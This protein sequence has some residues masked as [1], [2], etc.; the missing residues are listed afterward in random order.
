MSGRPAAS[1]SMAS[2]LRPTTGPF[3]SR[4]RTRPSDTASPAT[5][6]GRT[7]HPSCSS[8][9]SSRC[10]PYVAAHAGWVVLTF[11]LYATTM[12]AI[13]GDRIGYLLAGAFPAVLAN[14]VAGQ[15]G[16][17]TAALL[18]GTLGLMEKRPVL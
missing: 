10:F 4:C 3:T 7:L 14:A 9:R 17:V 6:N 13:V 8:R 1:C 5:I 2:R 11:P 15:N 16:F 12:R 18:G